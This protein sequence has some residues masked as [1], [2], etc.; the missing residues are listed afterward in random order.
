MK[1]KDIGPLIGDRREVSADEFEELCALQCTAGEI[2][3]WAG[4]TEKKLGAWC[5]RRYGADLA[6]TLATV[7]KDGLIAIRRAVFDLLRKNA[8]LVNKQMERYIGIPGPT[9]EEQARAA[10]EG[11]LY[12]VRQ[13]TAL[14]DPP[15]EHIRALFA[16]AG[17]PDSEDGGEDETLE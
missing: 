3:A 9:P 14:A 12:A 6:E 5:R 1:V 13:F 4:V 2:A 8:A 16:P 7:S 10:A 15:A 17:E 11:G